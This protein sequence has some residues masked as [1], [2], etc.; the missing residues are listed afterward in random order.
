MRQEPLRELSRYVAPALVCS[1]ARSFERSRWLSAADPS[2]LLREEEGREVCA[3][4]LQTGTCALGARCPYSHHVPLIAAGSVR[5]TTPTTPTTATQHE[6]P[7]ELSLRFPISDLPLSAL[8]PSL[9]PPLA[10]AV[11]VERSRAPRTDWS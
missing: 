4:L 1:C 5:A 3:S 10:Y 7:A 8:P 9:H 11:A 2:E 6:M